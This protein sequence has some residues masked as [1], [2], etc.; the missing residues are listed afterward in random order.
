MSG[1][2]GDGRAIE[3]P[4][5]SLPVALALGSNLGDRAVTLARARE[6]ITSRHG[7]IV[8]LSR[9]YET[10]PVGGP[11]QRPYLNQVLVLCARERAERMIESLLEIEAHLGRRRAERWGPRTIDIDVLLA[12]DSVI[13][14]PRLKVP[15]PRMAERSFVLVPL[16]EVLPGW[17]HPVLARTP[18][19]MLAPLGKA[20]VRLWSGGGH[21]ADGAR[22][23]DG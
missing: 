6:A 14:T 23:A 1:A 18:A 4:G 13:D 5:G 8:R 10:D 15:H 21:E 9:I 22:R 12:G 3:C 20:G 17:R 2:K 16:A 7:P 11:E 19:E